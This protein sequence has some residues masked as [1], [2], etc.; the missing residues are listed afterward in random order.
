MRIKGTI[1]FLFVF[2]I[3]IYGNAQTITIGTGTTYNS[4]SGYPAPYG[5]WYYGARH[6]FIIKASEITAAG[7]T[8][9]KYINSL[10]FN[11][12]SS[13][14]ATLNN[15]EIKIRSSTLTA[16][17]TPASSTTFQTG[18]TS[19]FGPSSF[20]DNT[21]W[22]THPFKAPFYW[23]GVSN[24]IV[25]VCF[26]NTAYTNNST[27]YYSTVTYNSS[28]YRYADVAN[29]C[30]ST[31]TTISTKRP[32]MRFEF[33]SP[34]PPVASFASSDSLFINVPYNFTNTSINYSS[35]YWDIKPLTANRFCN[36]YGC[37]IDSNTNINH[38]FNATGAYEILLVA[39]G[40]FGVDSIKKTIHV[41]NFS[42]IPK[43]N[44]YTSAQKII[45]PSQVFFYDS[46]LYGVNGWEWSISPLC[47]G[48]ATNPYQYPNTFMPSVNSQNTNFYAMDAGV[49]D[50][51]LKVWNDLGADSICKQKYLNVVQGYAMCNG[52]DSLSNLNAGYLYDIG[53]PDQNYQIG[54]IGQCNAGFVIN[55]TTCT[56]SI[57]LYVDRFKLRTT[58]TIQI[59][60]GG[61]S[62]SPLIKK[63]T[64]A[65]LPLSSKIMVA[66]SGKM[67]LKMTTGTGVFTTGDS[68]FVFHWETTSAAK[69]ICSSN[70]LCNG[71]SIKLYTPTNSGRTDTWK[72]NGQK[73]NAYTDSFCYAK[74]QGLYSLIVS[75]ASCS[76][77]A[78]F[79]LQGAQK[80]SA[81]FT[82]N[83]T[84]QCVND[85]EFVFTDTTKFN[86]T[87]TR[88]WNFGDQTS[89]VDSV[90]KK[91]Y[92]LPGI[93]PVTLKT[94]SVLGCKD[95]L[96]QYV[97]VVDVPVAS[98]VLSGSNNLCLNDS[99]M[100]S[101]ATLNAAKY[102]WYLNTEIL[103][104]DTISSIWTK[105]YG[106]YTLKV[107]NNLGCYSLSY[108]INV[109]SKP[110]PTKP[111]ITRAID[112]LKVISQN[113]ANW[114]FYDSLIAG[115]NQKYYLP[116]KKGK[117]S[118]VVDSNGCKNFS[119]PYDFN[120]T[121]IKSISSNN[122][123]LHIYP[124][125]ASSL[126][127][128][129]SDIPFE[130]IIT[131]IT[132]RVLLSSNISSN[133]FQVDINSLS[134]GLYFLKAFN[135]EK[136]SVMRFEKL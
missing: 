125:P 12:L 19:V 75:N 63:I 57:I 80:P 97:R 58:D 120:F 129:I 40:F 32:N 83:N 47:N 86:G 10:A 48:C 13:S 116:N 29:N 41:V 98:I 102:D 72:L 21:G 77:T 113:T 100:L 103:N 6:Q 24:I 104:A 25:E 123:F 61:K 1:F 84:I 96:T 28:A 44:F 31:A 35:S 22:N 39:K 99:V 105:L 90:Y 122:N 95:S 3:S 45:S 16:F 115:A 117:Y 18:F 126:L 53:G 23:D 73:I 131:D 59:R 110:G 67:F 121:G 76:D 94:T 70:Y 71:D 50:I 37:F 54:L 88:L 108:P 124:N 114:Y 78:Y 33:I 30:T 136:I 7:I 82:I 65:N 91:E 79:N 20:K 55:P 14:G 89:A 109:L 118:V 46:S 135:G 26:N 11:V 134:K 112:T 60:D 49:F 127:N 38:T 2:V 85:N 128:V 74:Y 4:T 133:T 8:G 34:N 51:C 132:G 81:K 68:G 43:A 66:R 130:F 42:R 15:F 5:N 101:S 36:K 107:T 106:A 27:M 17:T 93:F 119:D 92:L 69:I 87:F 56:D 9:A 64:G 62:T 52:N 111:I